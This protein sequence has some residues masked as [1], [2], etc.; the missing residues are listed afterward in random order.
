MARLRQYNTRCGAI[1]MMSCTFFLARRFIGG[2]AAEHFLRFI[3]AFSVIGIA[4]GVVSLMLV[5]GVMNGFSQDLR[6]KI[7]GAHPTVTVEGRPMFG[8]AAALMD[9]IREKVPGVTGLS[10]YITTQ[11]IYQSD[12]YRFGGVIR[13]VV[14]ETE[15]SV[16]DLARFFTRGTIADLNRGIALGSELARELEVTVGDRVTI[17]SMRG[18]RAYEV[19][20]IVES[21]VYAFDVTMGFVS[22]SSLQ[23]FLGTPGLVHGIGVRTADIYRSTEVA[24]RIRPLA[25][26]CEVSTWIERNKILFAAL[27]LEKKAMAVILILIVLVA[28]FNVASTLMIT[29]YRKTRQIGILRTLGLTRSDIWRLFFLQGLLLGME[30]LLSGLAVGGI[31]AEILR[32]Y[33]FIRLPQFIYNLSRLPIELSARDIFFISAAVIA[34]VAAASVYPAVR[35]SRLEPAE[36][37]RYE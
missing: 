9:E 19:V 15:A 32:K 17:L 18:Q 12:S 3:S 24:D 36:A 27:A 35:A 31:L 29:V 13:G 14:P 4:L 25:P 1:S 7:V 6:R 8:N 23:E 20:G 11:V 34:V 10:P 26:G 30:G 5:L 22:L 37:I 21:G 28:S 2:K 16:T 33:Q